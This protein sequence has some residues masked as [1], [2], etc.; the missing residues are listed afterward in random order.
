MLVFAVAGTRKDDEHYLLSY[1]PSAPERTGPYPYTAAGTGRPVARSQSELN[2]PA[3][4]MKKDASG[5]LQE[6]SGGSFIHPF[7]CKAYLFPKCRALDPWW[8]ST[9]LILKRDW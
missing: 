7:P 4:G 5:N 1:T 8:V 2:P 3:N 6:V 9:G